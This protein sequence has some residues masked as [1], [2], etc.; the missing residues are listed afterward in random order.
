MLRQ[1]VHFGS[2]EYKHEFKK[3]RDRLYK[4][5]LRVLRTQGIMDNSAALDIPRADIELEMLSRSE[6]QQ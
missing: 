2:K 1:F 3:A 5:K 4:R 6:F